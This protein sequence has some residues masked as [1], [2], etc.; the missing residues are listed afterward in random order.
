MQEM[1]VTGV[2]TTN[3]TGMLQDRKTKQFG[4]SNRIIR[5]PRRQQQ[6]LVSSTSSGCPKLYPLLMDQG[7]S[8]LDRAEEWDFDR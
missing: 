3:R 2:S 8:R 7:Q 6:P 5:S 4:M 1:T